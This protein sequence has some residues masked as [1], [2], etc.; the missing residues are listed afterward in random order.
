MIIAVYHFRKS[1]HRRCVIEFSIYQGSDYDTSSE[2][3]K[4]SEYTRVPNMPGLNEVLSMPDY[5]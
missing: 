3:A 2:V 4:G 1:L 5:V